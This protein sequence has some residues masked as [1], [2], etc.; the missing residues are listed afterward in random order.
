MQQL[1]LRT[2]IWIALILI[3]PLLINF[4]TFRRERPVTGGNER[5]VLESYESME[6]LPRQM[7]GLL[8]KAWK[9]CEGH[10]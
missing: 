2:K 6:G 3:Y 10:W 9:D 5:K 4:T 8:E 1:H 7:C